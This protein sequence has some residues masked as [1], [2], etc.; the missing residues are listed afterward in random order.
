MK[1]IPNE[2]PPIE[3]HSAKKTAKISGEGF[4]DILKGKM[5]KVP[6]ADEKSFAIPPSSN[7]ASIRFNLGNQTDT[8][9]TL[10]R[11]DRF[12]NLLET[13][14]K[15][16]E[17]PRI[18]LKETSSIIDQLERQTQELLPVLESLPEGDGIKDLLNRLLPELSKL[19]VCD[20]Q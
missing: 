10:V 4:Q 14:Q 20:V 19:R 6:A 16:M 9:Q 2:I 11:M 7:L 1:I 12:L 13:Y 3:Q 17:D 15:Q 18:T 5:E 8:K